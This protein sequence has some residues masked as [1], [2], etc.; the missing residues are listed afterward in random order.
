MSD[1]P[2]EKQS[3]RRLL[4]AAGAAGAG[5]VAPRIGGAVAAAAIASAPEE[6]DVD[7][8]LDRKHPRVLFLRPRGRADRPRRGIAARSPRPCQ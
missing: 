2:D 8:I 5:R 6:M 3:C 7:R 1:E 4:T